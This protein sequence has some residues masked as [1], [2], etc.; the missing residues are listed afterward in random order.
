[1]HRQKHSSLYFV[2]R[3][4]LELVTGDCF[5]CDIA[6]CHTAQIPSCRIGCFFG[7]L[8]PAG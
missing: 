7:N 1:V 6:G 3:H 4:G 8:D 5:D 2:G